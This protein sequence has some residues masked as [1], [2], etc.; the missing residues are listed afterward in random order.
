MNIQLD[1]YFRLIWLFIL[2]NFKISQLTLVVK[3]SHRSHR[4]SPNLAKHG[5]LQFDVGCFIY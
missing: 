4:A 3:A 5:F 1:I 2:A